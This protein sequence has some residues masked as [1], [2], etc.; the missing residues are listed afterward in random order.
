MRKNRRKSCCCG[1]EGILDRWS[2]DSKGRQCP[3]GNSSLARNTLLYHINW[4]LLD[5]KITVYFLTDLGGSEN[6]INRTDPGKQ[7]S[8]Q[9][10]SN[11][12]TLTGER[13]YIFKLEKY[14]SVAVE[15]LG[16]TIFLPGMDTLPIKISILFVFHI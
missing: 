12:T 2:G 4:L 7:V 11:P 14:K 13:A 1:G 15:F 8:T 6:F 10:K 16:D 9:V 3:H 5:T